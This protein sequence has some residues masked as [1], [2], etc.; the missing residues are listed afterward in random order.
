[1][2]GCGGRE[3]QRKKK[4]VDCGRVVEGKTGKGTGVAGR[5]GPLTAD[6]E[7]S[8][9]RRLWFVSRRPTCCKGEVAFGP[10]LDAR[11]PISL[12]RMIFQ[13]LS[14]TKMHIYP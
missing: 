5:V 1:V 13:H 11:P 10:L 4:S 12:D 2:R 3:D 8:K 6:V 7:A 9:W 14:P